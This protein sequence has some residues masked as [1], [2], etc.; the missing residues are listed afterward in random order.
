MANMY[1]TQMKQE[2]ARLN[3]INIQIQ[4]DLIEAFE[5]PVYM[6]VVSEDEMPED[7][8]YFIIETDD[9]TQSDSGKS[10]S[11]NVTITLWSTN[12]PDPTLDHLTT[13]AIGLG[14]KLRLVSATNDYIIMEKTNVIINMFT[15]NFARRV[16][17]GC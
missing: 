12:R 9:Y 6:N 5:I 1:L 17:V 10:A 14:N 15:C 16:K 13:I 11:E 3:K 7:L 2:A 8:T 4:A